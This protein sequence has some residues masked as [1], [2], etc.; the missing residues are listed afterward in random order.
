MFEL[1]FSSKL[2]EKIL[3]YLQANEQAYGLELADYLQETLNGV[4]NT[5]KRLEKSGLLASTLQGK[6][7]VYQ[8]NPRYPFKQ[9]MMA[10]ITKAYSFLPEEQ[11]L[12]Y[13]EIRVRRRPRRQGKPL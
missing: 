12:K 11:K 5:L 13:Y 4:Q 6:T 9:E 2:T 7:R 3:F 1:I 10:L 8:I